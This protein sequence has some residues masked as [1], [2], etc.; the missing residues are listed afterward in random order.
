M[1]TTAATPHRAKPPFHML[2]WQARPL[3]CP[4]RQRHTMGCWSTSHDHPGAHAPGTITARGPATASLLLCCTTASD[5][6]R[7]GASR[8]F[9]C[10]PPVRLGVW[11][12]R[13]GSIAGRVIAGAGGSTMLLSCMRW[14]ASEQGR[15]KQMTSLIPWARRDKPQTEAQSPGASSAWA[16]YTAWA[17]SEL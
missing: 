11:R 6:W 8:P 3:P 17:R 9:C 12:R 7:T 5:R 15:S 13:W 14:N 2:R 16:P 1:C 4:R 10:V